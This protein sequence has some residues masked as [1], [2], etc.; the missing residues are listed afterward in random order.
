MV[1]S[2]WDSHIHAPTMQQQE[3]E[4][5]PGKCVNT[6]VFCNEPNN[7]VLL[8]SLEDQIQLKRVIARVKYS[9]ALFKKIFNSREI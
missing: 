8:N 4:Q 3:A 2:C 5:F 7:K 6:R 9:R 1:E